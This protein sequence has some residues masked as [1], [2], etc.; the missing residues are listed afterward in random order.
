MRSSLVVRASD[1]NAEVATNLCW[2]PAS[3]DI[4]ESEGRQM[5]QC[6]ITYI[7]DDISFLAVRELTGYTYIGRDETGSVHLPGDRMFFPWTGRSSFFHL[8]F[9]PSWLNVRQKAAV[10]TLCTLWGNCWWWG[11]LYFNVW[12]WCSVGLPEGHF[13][14]F[15]FSFVICTLL[16]ALT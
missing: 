6:W 14:Q 8:G 2:I 13:G 1:C 4:V 5:K 9:W 15:T 12:I 10:T 3:S 11:I 16:M 7:K